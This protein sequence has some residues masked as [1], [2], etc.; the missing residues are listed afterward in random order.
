MPATYRIDI[1]RKM[2]FTLTTGTL[3][4]ADCLKHRDQLLKDPK[5]DSSFDQ[6]ADCTQVTSFEVSTDGVH[7]LADHNPFGEGSRRAFV[8]STD[9]CY[10]MA[11]M[12]QALTDHHAHVLTVFRDLATARNWLRL[13]PEDAQ[14]ETD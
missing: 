5:M 4:D 10:G 9:H 8:V 11:R 14:A 3:T 2:V 13:P 7:A 1:E 12:Y 6:L